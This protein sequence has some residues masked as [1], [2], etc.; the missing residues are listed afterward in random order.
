KTVEQHARVPGRKDKAVAVRPPRGTRVVMQ[1]A[2]PQDVRHRRR[3]QRHAGMARA[4]LLHRINGQGP[5]AV[6]AEF[7]D[8]LDPSRHHTAPA[9]ARHARPYLLLLS[10]TIL[11]DLPPAG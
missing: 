11:L 6:D 4:G 3:A 9:R 7:L 8:R 1:V 2:R 10:P 5:D